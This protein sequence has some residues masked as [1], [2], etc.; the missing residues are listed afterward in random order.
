MKSYNEITETSELVNYTEDVERVETWM[1]S[2]YMYKCIWLE[3]NNGWL[4]TTIMRVTL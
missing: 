1:D 2:A 4:P 3:Q